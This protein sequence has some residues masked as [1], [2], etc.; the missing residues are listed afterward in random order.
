MSC[1]QN[2]TL[3]AAIH[4]ACARCQ[5]L[6]AAYQAQLSRIG[7]MEI[8]SSVKQILTEA[9]REFKDMALKFDWERDLSVDVQ[10]KG[11]SRVLRA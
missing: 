11:F 7:M 6:L 3:P 8:P 10:D 5:A 2:A 1:S 9:E 4:G